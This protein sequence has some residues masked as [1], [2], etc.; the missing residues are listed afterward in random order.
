MLNQINKEV[1]EFVSIFSSLNI[2]FFKDLN[3]EMSSSKQ[4]ETLNLHLNEERITL[5]KNQKEELDLDLPNQLIQS[6]TKTMIIPLL[7]KFIYVLKKETGFFKLKCLNDNGLALLSDNS[8]FPITLDA[9][10]VNFSF[11]YSKYNYLI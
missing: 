10:N 2:C 1:G 8:H 3:E 6:T 11:F 5:N 7:R 9:K 4:L